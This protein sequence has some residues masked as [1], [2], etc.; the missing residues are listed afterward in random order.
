MPPTGVGSE[1]TAW[2]DDLHTICYI[3]QMYE[4]LVM[5]FWGS[6]QSFPAGSTANLHNYTSHHDVMHTQIISRLLFS[7]SSTSFA[8]KPF[9]ARSISVLYFATAYACF[10]LCF[11]WLMNRLCFLNG[12]NYNWSMTSKQEECLEILGQ[13]TD[14]HSSEKSVKSSQHWFCLAEYQL[15]Q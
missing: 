1:K 6:C 8:F 11:W 2:T 10:S 5:V 3:W 14:M 4:Q 9:M 13:I 7:I 12:E 15:I